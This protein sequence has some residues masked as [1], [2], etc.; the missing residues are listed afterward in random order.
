MEQPVIIRRSNRKTLS[1][2]ITKQ[3]E[4]YIKAPLNMSDADI[5]KIRKT[6]ENWILKHINLQKTR[7]DKAKN[8]QFSEKQIKDLKNQAKQMLE[9]R[10]S[11]YSKMMGVTPAGIKVTSAKARW[12]SC[13]GKNNLCFP[14]RIVFL[15]AELVDCIV[16]HELAHIKIKNHGKRFYAE[17]LRYMPD[18][19]Q[20]IR[21]IYS[22]QNEMGL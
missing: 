19:K 7:N 18:Y 15:P 13:S 22:L 21:Q 17:V 14:Y 20:R 10:V 8:Y 6:H 2:S 4:V 16:V 5:E 9:E 1:I 3:L 12:G 11:Y